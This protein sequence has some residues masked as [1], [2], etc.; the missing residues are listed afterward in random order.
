VRVVK[1]DMESTKIDFVLH[2]AGEETVRHAA[3]KAAPKTASKT[4]KKPAPKEPTPK[5]S[6][7][8]KKK[9]G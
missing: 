2:E 8:G 3:P 6:G 1:V 5:K 9:H 4:A 7:R